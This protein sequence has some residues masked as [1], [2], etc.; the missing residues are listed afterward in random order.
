MS[1][2]S[3]LSVQPTASAAEIRAAYASLALSAHPDKA[4]GSASAFQALQAAYAVLRDEASRAEYD[5]TL[6][7][8]TVR[9]AL[10][11]CEEVPLLEF[12]QRADGARVHPC[13]CGDAFV[14]TQADA[15]AG[16]NVLTCGGCS[17]HIKAVL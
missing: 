5:A 13:R 14:L 3:A 1:L 2:Y 17:L 4:G 11:I 8:E 9:V 7:S 12:R 10:P 15:S 6:T 16:V